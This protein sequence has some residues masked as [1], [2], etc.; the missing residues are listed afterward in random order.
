MEKFSQFLSDFAIYAPAILG[1]L[2]DYI[3]QLSTGKRRW[4]ALGFCVHIM[5]AGFFG[6]LIG[7]TASGLEYDIQLVSASSGMGG[8]LGV[9][10]ADLIVHKLTKTER[11]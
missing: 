3:N 9:R 11:K 2:V 4:S 5:S 7:M 6:W 8:F 10:V 1:G